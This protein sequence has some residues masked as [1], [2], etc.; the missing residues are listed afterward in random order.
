MKVYYCGSGWDDHLEHLGWSPP[1]GKIVEVGAPDE[2]NG[3]MVVLFRKVS[4]EP[5]IIEPLCCPLCGSPI[6]RAPHHP[7]P[8]FAN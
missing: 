3:Y 8:R 4:G 6:H 1:A 5:S 7:A 2:R